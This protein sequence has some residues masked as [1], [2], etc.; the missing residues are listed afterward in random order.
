MLTSAGWNITN[1]YPLTETGRHLLDEHRCAAADFGRANYEWMRS[2]SYERTKRW[3]DERDRQSKRL[4]AAKEAIERSVRLGVNLWSTIN[5]P[6]PNY[7][8]TF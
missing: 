4:I 8:E 2:R 7:E 5:G 3:S 1:T 6:V